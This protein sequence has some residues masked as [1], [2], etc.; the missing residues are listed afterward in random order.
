MVL[1]CTGGT[2]SGAAAGG[3]NSIV[4]V[5]VA[6]AQAIFSETSRDAVVTYFLFLLR[7]AELRK[8][9]I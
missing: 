4:G 1:L 8:A 3:G 6:M 7:V 9:I 5:F 2:P